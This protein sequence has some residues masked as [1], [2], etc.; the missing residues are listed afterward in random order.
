MIEVLK[1]LLSHPQGAIG[2]GLGAILIL[3]MAF[4][5]LVA[6][7]DPESFDYSARLVGP[8]ANHWM[9]TDQFGRD[10]LS[11]LLWG[12]RSTVLLGFTATLI[13]TSLGAAVGILSGFLG[14]WIDDA[15]M[16]VVDATMAI[17]NLLFA[18]LIVTVLGP[19][20]L[21]A[22][23]AIGIAFAPGMA[24]IARSVTLATR[25]HD[26]VS[27]AVARGE[28]A[29]YIMA[30]EILP[31]MVAPVIVEGTIRVAFAIMLLAT[32]SF[33]GL[34][35]QPP[36]P[37]WGL[38]IAEAR[39]FMFRNAWTIVWPGLAIATVA[40]AFNLLGDGLRDVLNPRT[41]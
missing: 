16:R 38:M 8:T 4:G 19:S 32:L 11:R 18:L 3:A 31:N 27:A 40:I 37:E 22:V 39:G 14:G 20:G 9:G 25:N 17:P 1:R 30:R 2:L 35:A 10:I 24:R 6:P 41:R 5:P 21:N 36:A 13:G 12:A 23:I 33:L 26:Y 29:A 28:S 7:Y 34:G 15:I